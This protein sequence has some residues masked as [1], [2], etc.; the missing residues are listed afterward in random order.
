M[1]E[2]AVERMVSDVMAVFDYTLEYMK[3]MKQLP[4]SNFGVPTMSKVKFSF[5]FFTWRMVC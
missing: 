4:P 1:K 2:E 3:K 5:K